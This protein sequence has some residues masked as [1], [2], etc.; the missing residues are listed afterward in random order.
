MLDPGPPRQRPLRELLKKSPKR[1]GCDVFVGADRCVRP[2][3]PKERG[4]CVGAAYMRPMTGGEKRPGRIYASPTHPARREPS[5][6]GRVE[7]SFLNRVQPPQTANASLLTLSSRRRRRTEGCGKSNASRRARGHPSIR[8]SA[9]TQDE[10]DKAFSTA[11][12]RKES[13]DRGGLF[14]QARQG[15][16]G[17][18]F[19]FK[20]G[21]G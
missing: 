7:P 2:N 18:G 21:G 20:A 8:G 4:R 1:W 3:G 16:V 19:V 11:P 17:G 5:L 12:M 15:G 10:A 13:T 6:P 14:L 9:A